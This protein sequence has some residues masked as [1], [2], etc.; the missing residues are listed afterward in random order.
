[1]LSRLPECVMCQLRP[2]SSDYQMGKYAAP[3]PERPSHNCTQLCPSRASRP[4]LTPSQR[5]PTLSCVP[6]SLLTS[7][8]WT[9][10]ALCS[11]TVSC[12]PRFHTS[13]IVRVPKSVCLRFKTLPKI[14]HIMRFP[15]DLYASVLMSCWSGAMAT[16]VM[17]YNCRLF[18]PYRGMRRLVWFP[19]SNTV[20]SSARLTRRTVQS[21]SHTMIG[22]VSNE[23]WQ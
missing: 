16:L 1:M 18:A 6:E 5:R 11:L 17:I 8:L 10:S 9:S 4:H 14:L 15:C 2:S 7:S 13:S 23:L 19:M 21:V 12:T 3:V 22:R 20:H